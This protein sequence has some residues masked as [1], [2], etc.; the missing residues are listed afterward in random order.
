MA[1]NLTL[2]NDELSALAYALSDYV[3]ATGPSEVDGDVGPGAHAALVSLRN[4]LGAM[5]SSTQ[6]GS[7]LF[8]QLSDTLAPAASH[9]ESAPFAKQVQLTILDYAGNPAFD[10][11][12][13]QARE[14]LVRV[15]NPSEL[16]AIEKAS[17][18]GDW[19]VDFREDG[20]TWASIVAEGGFVGSSKYR[21]RDYAIE[22]QL[23]AR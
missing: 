22:L 6:S 19:L 23:D 10:V 8:Q 17:F 4:R 20:Q 11:T 5:D 18:D 12:A 3:D 13:D 1:H 15:W 2:T 14:I 7:D 21:G 16:G 9:P